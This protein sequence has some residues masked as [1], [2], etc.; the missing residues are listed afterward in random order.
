MLECA[1]FDHPIPKTP[2]EAA[3][4]WVYRLRVHIAE[5]G[6]GLPRVDE[7]Y[8]HGN[9]FDKTPFYTVQDEKC[10]RLRLVPEPQHEWQ[11]QLGKVNT[12]TI[13]NYVRTDGFV[14]AWMQTFQ[15]CFT[16]PTIPVPGTQVQWSAAFHDF[17]KAAIR[18]ILADYIAPYETALDGMRDRCA[19]FALPLHANIRANGYGDIRGVAHD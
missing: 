9:L 12:V 17:V 2:E 1:T 8:V 16:G 10:T 14:E 13:D 4:L 19:C 18:G 15:S 5:D 3:H 6:D 7:I 11:R